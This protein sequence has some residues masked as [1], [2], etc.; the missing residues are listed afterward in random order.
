MSRVE[1]TSR[2]GHGNPPPKQE[3][4]DQAFSTGG[5]RKAYIA[6]SD[7]N[8]PKHWPIGNYRY[9]LSD[10]Q[11]ETETT[12]RDPLA[13]RATV[14]LPRLIRT[15]SPQM[16]PSPLHQSMHVTHMIVHHS[17]PTE[18]AEKL[19]ECAETLEAKNKP[20]TARKIRDVAAKITLQQQN[21][22]DGFPIS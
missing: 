13:E 22:L 14:Q 15:N 2:T 20:I 4:R 6:I 12:A 16:L 18:A 19:R 7:R 3:E 9:G 10:A 1:T 11:S 21:E 5:G 8:K 17:A